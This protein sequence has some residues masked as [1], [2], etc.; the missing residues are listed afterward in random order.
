MDSEDEPEYWDLDEEDLEDD[1]QETLICSQGLPSTASESAINQLVHVTV[2]FILLWSCHYRISANAVD[3]LVR[4]LH[5]FL[6][7]LSPYTPFLI[8]NIL[9]YFPTTL[10]MLR[11]R[12]GLHQDHFT[13]FTICTAC[14]SL[15]LFE[16]CYTTNP[17]TKVR[18]PKLCSHVEFPN[19]PHRSRRNPCG[20][21]LLKEVVLKNGS[22]ALYPKKVYCYRSIKD[23]LKDIMS[24][25]GIFDSCEEWRCRNVP[26]GYL[27]DVYDGKVWQNFYDV[28]GTPFLSQ[29]HNV[30]FMLNCDWFQPYDF[31]QY[32]VG[33]LYMV[34][35]NLPRAIR[36]KTENVIIVGII[37]GPSEPSEHINSYLWPLVDD[38]L[39]LWRKGI[40]IDTNTVRAALLC[41]ACDL[42]AAHKLCGFLS[43]S[44][45]HACSRCKQYFPYDQEL[46]KM[47][48]AGFSQSHSPRTQSEHKSAGVKWLMAPTKKA[49]DDVENS[50]G[51][52]FTKLNLL[53]YFNCVRFT[54]IDPMHNLFLGTAKHMMKNIWLPD[55]LIQQKDIDKIHSVIKNALVPSFVGRIPQKILSGFSTFTADQWK[56]WSMLFSLICLHGVLPVQHIECWRNFIQMCLLFCTP[57][58]TLNDVKEANA[59]ATKFGKEFEALYGKQRVTPNMHLHTHLAECILDYGPVYSFWLYSFERYNGI[60]GSYHTNQKSI[61]IQVMRKFLDHMHIRTVASNDHVVDDHM[62]FFRIFFT[63][64]IRGSFKET[65]CTTIENHFNSTCHSL[66][67]LPIEEVKPNMLYTYQLNTCTLVPPFKR[68]LFDS[69]SLRY[70]K[71]A[72]VHFLPDIDVDSIAA[73]YELYCAISLWGDRLGSEHS[74]LEKSSYIQAY[75]ASR[76]GYICKVCYDLYIGRVEYYFRQCIVV[77]GE[78][79]NVIMASVKWFCHHH[80]RHAFGSP[81]EVCSSSL[82]VPFGPASFL[83]VHRIKNMCVVC[84]VVLAGETVLAVTPLTRKV[85]L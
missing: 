22:K 82:H 14:D 29:P 17:I 54:I 43:H 25:T 23:G 70:L 63:N 66:L 11:K 84:P 75:W 52:R 56:N 78:Q 12:Y 34:I 47:I 8:A 77:K 58:I 53:P 30:A 41:I 85:F 80:N 16:D 46:G 10:H 5:H 49:R 76:N 26:E 51:S 60:L 72:Y 40:K 7:Q 3:H 45:H 62:E 27:G 83:P 69:D 38:L 28:D 24:R 42:P 15:Y 81:V 1:F 44:S 48:Y 57:T 32:S 36:F 68:R 33:V 9:A 31:T 64:N 55:G 59:I 61:E 35:L 2:L 37:P 67:T 19:H 13:K 50:T 71:E 20:N 39:G 73:S 18:T 21:P 65:I 6:S 4:Y 79:I 74:R